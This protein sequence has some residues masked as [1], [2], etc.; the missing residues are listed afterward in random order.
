MLYL[1]IRQSLPVGAVIITNTQA[2]ETPEAAREA[3]PYKPIGVE[4]M[5]VPASV[6]ERFKRAYKVV[7]I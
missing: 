3:S 5:D 1:S 4:P 6:G 2:H 7:K